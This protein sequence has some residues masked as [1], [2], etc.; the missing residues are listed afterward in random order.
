MTG[1]DGAIG[2]AENYRR[3]AV[4]EAA[5]GSPSYE[6]LSLAVAGDDEVLSFLERLPVAK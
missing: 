1:L 6:Q 5:G 3:F 4:H 2:T